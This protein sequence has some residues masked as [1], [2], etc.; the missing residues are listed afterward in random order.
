L[1]GVAFGWLGVGPAWAQAWLPPAGEASFSLGFARSSADHHIN[2][3]GEAVGPGLMEWDNAVT[4]LGYGIT[5]RWA[6]RV[7]LPLVFSRY[8]G[9]T[10][11]PP[12]TPG[13]R[14]WDDGTWNG[15]FQDLRAEVRFKATTG[16][17]VVTP[18]VA[19]V[20]PT[21]DYGYLAHSAQGRHVVEGQF[22]VS[23][24]RL[25]DPVLPNAYVQARYLYTVPEKFLDVSMNRSDVFVDVG[26]LVTSSLTVSAMGF[27]R[28][29]H[30]G[31]RATIDFPPPSSPRFKYHDRLTMTEYFRLGAGANYALT[32]SIDVGA[33]WYTT[34]SGR[35]DVEMKGFALTFSY[36]FSPAQLIR[37]SHGKKPPS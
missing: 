5:D 15:A 29:T 35:N 32:G 11:H 36:G 25:L 18:A 9:K 8:D 23:V 17:L 34:V 20:I 26:Y 14:V 27:W 24:G 19:I 16:S 21:S 13:G 4:E 30:G 12:A 2:Y 1:A 6:V 28:D 7:G 33:N 22:G 31:W 3:K 37:K 10:P